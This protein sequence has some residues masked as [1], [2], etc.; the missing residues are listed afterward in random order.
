MS[1]PKW[2]GHLH[3]FTGKYIQIHTPKRDVGGPAKYEHIFNRK[4]LS[5]IV[6]PIIEGTLRDQGGDSQNDFHSAS[7]FIS[8]LKQMR[9]PITSSSP[10]IET[11]L[12]SE[13]YFEN[14]NAF[15]FSLLSCVE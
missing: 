14:F 12:L 10:F 2:E 4:F 13:N 8:K 3:L 5:P 15:C 9:M 1:R 11:S 6:T 7:G